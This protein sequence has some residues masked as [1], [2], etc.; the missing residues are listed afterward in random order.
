MPELKASR[1]GKERTKVPEKS[2]ILG[3]ES[4]VISL[5]KTEEIKE[6]NYRGCIKDVGVGWG[7]DG[8]V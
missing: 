2:R 8:Q 1:G 3:T 6:G 4:N 5:K 7:W